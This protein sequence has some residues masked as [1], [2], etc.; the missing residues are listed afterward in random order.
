MMPYMAPVY[1]STFVLASQ[2]VLVNVVV[3]VLMKQLEDAKDVV[4]PANSQASGLNEDLDLSPDGDGRE[5]DI[6][7]SNPNIKSKKEARNAVDDIEMTLQPRDQ[8]TLSRYDNDGETPELSFNENEPLLRSNEAA[9][10]RVDANSNS[11]DN[12]KETSIESDE[13]DGSS[14]IPK[15]KLNNQN[16]NNDNKYN[17]NNNKDN[18]DE[19]T[20]DGDSEVEQA[21][22]DILDDVVERTEHASLEPTEEHLDVDILATVKALSGLRDSVISTCV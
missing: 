13:P 9:S 2:F 3:A 11:L 1:F 10:D 8:K 17:N 16:D 21:V 6:Q 18:K 20:E 15:Y 12:A 5:D 4:S 7:L 19:D 22:K 14:S